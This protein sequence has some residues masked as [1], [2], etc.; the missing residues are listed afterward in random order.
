MDKF[1]AGIL[2]LSR[3]WAD[4][5]LPIIQECLEL[6]LTDTT[7][8]WLNCLEHLS[9][10]F[11]GSMFPE[12]VLEELYYSKASL[13]NH[14]SLYERFEFRRN[15]LD[16]L[17]TIWEAITEKLAGDPM[18]L[19]LE[20]IN[21]GISMMNA[22]MA[23]THCLDTKSRDCIRFTIFQAS[24]LRDYVLGAPITAPEPKN[25]TGMV[26][27]QYLIQN[28]IMTRDLDFGSCVQA[29]YGYQLMPYYFFLP[30]ILDIELL[31]TPNPVPGKVLLVDGG[32]KLTF[33]I[34]ITT[35]QHQLLQ[36][37]VN[38]PHSIR[39]ELLRSGEIIISMQVPL[40]KERL[41]VKYDVEISN[42][43]SEFKL[44]C[45]LVGSNTTSIIREETWM[46]G[47]K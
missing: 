22:I 42:Q 12:N 35:N 19:F 17:I 9:R 26:H 13:Q 38:K 31:V 24:I 4:L 25:S 44:M 36:N 29:I 2:L 14:E 16:A 37:F 28:T 39:F 46:I 3:G 47:P 5:S 1:D 6:C 8:S 21:V 33:Q 11:S 20:Q 10:A 41:Q 18:A 45:A 34:E 27:E 23:G 32:E 15:Y 43:I 30:N 40:T 7:F